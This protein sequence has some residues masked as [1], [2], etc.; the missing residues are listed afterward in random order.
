MKLRPQCL[1]LILALAMAAAVKSALLL[2]HSVPFNSDE[3]IVGLMARHI[4]RGERPTFFYGQAYLGSLDAW[5][6]AGVFSVFGPSTLGI[7]LVQ[8]GLYLALIATTYW[9]AL[10]IYRSQWIAGA[11]SLLLAIRTVL[12]ALYTT[13]S[14]GGYGEVLVLG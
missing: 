8:F 9:L 3:A 12:V 14:L 10:R 7:R 11:A 6:V 4:L 13:V 1:A 5:L 2:T